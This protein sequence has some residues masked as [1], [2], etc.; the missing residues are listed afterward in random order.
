MRR[1]SFGLG[2]V[3]L[4]AAAIRPA[5]AQQVSGPLVLYTSQLEPDAAATVEAFRR[6]HP[7]VQ[8]EWIRGGTGQ[9]MTRLRAEIA[10]GQPRPDLLLLADSL[11]FEGLKAEGR[12]RASPEV[13]TGGIPAEHLD[14]GRGY[15]GT[16]LITTGFMHHVRAPFV[17]ARWTDLLDARARNQVAMPSPAVSGAAAIH[18]TTLVQ[19]P[20][21]GWSYVE[22]LVQ[23]GVQA[24]GGNGP[25]MQA[26]SGAER[27][28]GI[29]I[30]YLPI[31]EAAKGAPVRFVFPED[32]V[33]AITEPVGILSTARNVPA[34]VAFVDFLLSR[35]GQVL[36]SGQGFLPADPAVAPPAGFP[37][38]RSIK[39]MPFDAARAAREQPEILRRFAQLA[40]G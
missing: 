1:R 23:N 16:K 28:F 13:Q 10:A 22:R 34:A 38:P 29:V 39:V 40:G 24:R 20:A 11:T 36:A 21:L 26:V 6:R 31:R 19:N 7:A 30:D 17:P 25:V 35:E 27:A 14:P 12:L 18:I 5:A 3:S 2:L 9:I 4:A 37:D 15:F 8:V 33:S 32:G